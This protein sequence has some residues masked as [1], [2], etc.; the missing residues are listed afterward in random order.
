MKFLIPTITAL[1]VDRPDAFAVAPPALIVDIEDKNLLELFVRDDGEEAAGAAVVGVTSRFNRLRPPRCR[2]V[3][4]WCRT[5]LSRREASTDS[6]EAT[7]RTKV[8]TSCN[9][10]NRD[11]YRVCEADFG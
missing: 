10:E 7:R 2:L 4:S 8:K 6:G 5:K 11:R 3:A 1:L 9:S